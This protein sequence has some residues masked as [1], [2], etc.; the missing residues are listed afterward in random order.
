[1]T[2]RA[3]P[4][5]RG[6]PAPRAPRAWASYGPHPQR[7]YAFLGDGHRGAVVGPRGDVVWLC[8]PT[9]QD[10]AVLAALVGG[11]GVYAV[12]PLVPYVAGGAYEAGT[13]VWG[14]RWVTPGGVVESQDALVAPGD[15]HVVRLL[16]TVRADTEDAPLRVV[17]DLRAGFGADRVRG[18]RLHDDAGRAW[19]RA[20]T[21]RVGGLWFRW[22]GADDATRPRSG[23]WRG[24]FLLETTLPAGSSRDLLLEI[25]DR[26]FDR[27]DD[28]P[29]AAEELWAT[30]RRWWADAVPSFEATV[31]PR[32]ARHAYAVL[33]GLTVPGGGM[34]A[35]ATLGLPERAA[36][37]RNYDYRYVWLRDQA[38][39]GHAAAVDHPHP[40]LDDA[41]SFAVARI[42][43]HGP[44]L[45]PAYT[46]D[47]G[48][49]PRERRLDLAGYPGGSDVVGNH[50][51]D[52]FQLDTVGE[53][54]QLLARAAALDHL[55]A[56]GRRALRILCDVARDRW[57]EPDAG[58]W[59]LE[60]A[61]WTQSRLAVVAGLRSAA[62]VSD[63][64]RA[65]ELATL[66]DR[67]LARTSERCLRP[68]GAW[69]RR[70]GAPGT[71]ASLL[72]APVRGALPA[73][74]PR[75]RATVRAVTG[76]L[77][78]D[79]FVYRFSPDERP[80]GEAEGAFLLCGFTTALAWWYE[81]DRA[82]AFR[83]FERTAAAC[84]PAGLFAEEYDVG[85][86]QLR[87]NLPQAFVHAAL[88]ESAQRLA[89]PP[90]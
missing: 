71:D 30:T 85:E 63:R 7:D 38:Y 20:W 27:G 33:R 4:S 58:I 41:V 55:D 80:L 86:R 18:A 83:W 6:E 39:A 3:G 43:E 23:P 75:T 50:V 69:A 54:I 79:G 62:A 9:W 59:E 31:S 72:L 84:G 48:P 68:D 13:L 24:A 8:A 16:R 21:G 28:E 78:Q 67:I 34:V 46:V 66:A 87:G 26:P 47:G 5:P 49:L 76:E 10:D 74:D 60:D 52:Q 32:D 35:A 89:R 2:R 65:G 82:E 37:G 73:D 88:L 14:A 12:T 19:G 40:L 57:D 45:A 1:M 51:V 90:A 29:P 81:D 42:L 64:H 70:P 44:A 56:D 17:L 36:G 25:S 53:L 15:P 61:W 77:V 22:W 11:E